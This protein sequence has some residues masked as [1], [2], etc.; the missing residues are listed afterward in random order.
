MSRT[1]FRYEGEHEVVAIGV[2][3]FVVLWA[4][5]FLGIMG[6]LIANAVNAPGAG[7]IV[8]AIFSPVIACVVIAFAASTLNLV[9]ILVVAPL[10]LT[11]HAILRNPFADKGPP[12]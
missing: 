6:G 12:R 2:G 7:T 10:A 3:L 1:W 4:V 9:F 5:V 8:L 11:I